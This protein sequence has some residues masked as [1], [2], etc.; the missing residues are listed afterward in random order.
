MADKTFKAIERK[1]AAVLGTKRIP[2]AFM[3]FRGDH[4]RDAPDCETPLLAVQIKHGYRFPG[5]LKEWLAGINKN[6]GP[7]T[8]IVVWHEKGAPVTE[9]V[10]VM[11][12]ADL[13][14]LCERVPPPSP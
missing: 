14:A 9:S 7:K 2:S 4:G 13:A 8:G 1:V 10:V 3:A 11:R 12:L 6:A 5:Y